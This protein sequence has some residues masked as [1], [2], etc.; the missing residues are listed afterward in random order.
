MQPLYLHPRDQIAMAM[1]RIYNHRLTTTC[2]GNLSILDEAGDMWIT[3]AG[4][5]KGSITPRDVVRIRADGTAEGRWAPS[6]EH[7]FHRAVYAARPDLKAILHAHPMSLVAFSLAGRVPETRLLPQ[8][9][10]WNGAVAFVPW[11]PS[12]SANLGEAV[13]RRFAAGFNSLILQNHGAVCGGE[14]L[15]DAFARF[16]TLEIAA[17]AEIRARMVGT[18]APTSE[19]DL[20]LVRSHGMARWA[21]LPVSRG[22]G[23]LQE[24]EA[25]ER[26]CECIERG[27]RQRLFLPSV[28]SVSVRTGPDSFVV[29][30]HSCDRM[31]LRPEALVLV[32]AGHAES[33][34]YPSSYARLH[35]AIYLSHPEAN[36][37]IAAAPLNVLA[38]SMCRKAVNV[39]ALPDARAHLGN[40]G[41]IPFAAV[42][43]TP[44]SAVARLSA[45]NPALIIENNG[46][47]VMGQDLLGAYNALDVLE[48]AADALVGALPLRDAK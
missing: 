11:A 10:R 15:L 31:A 33:G 43:R 38:F 22:G 12:G 26:I 47:V 48:N 13:G 1:A 9:W 28:G 7:P 21:E 5:D 18:P 36:A 19:Q 2:G 35:D 41:T 42:Y 44:A 40:V 16:D 3:P 46:A 30:P 8:A 45:E 24:R 32:R 17:R 20:A 25:R 37:V 23:S 39:K 27:L 34:K 14:S 6:S 4:V 29:T